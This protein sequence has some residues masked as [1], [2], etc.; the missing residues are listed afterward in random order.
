MSNVLVA[1]APQ[2]VL[3]LIY[4][5]YNGIFTCMLA[6]RE[7][8]QFAQ[9]RTGLRVSDGPRGSQ[10]SVYF[11]QLPYRFAVPIMILSGVLHW[12]VSQSI[13]LAAI[14]T[15]DG[16]R[17]V[18]YFSS[19]DLPGRIDRLTCGFSPLAIVFVIGLAALMLLFGVGMGRLR[20]VAGIPT[21]GS[22]S[23]VLSAACHVE[24]R[25]AGDG[26]EM[27]CKRLQWGVT[28]PGGGVGYDEIG[29]CGFSDTAVETPKEFT[30]YAGWKGMEHEK[31]E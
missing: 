21:A 18:L 3:S 14:E 28:R 17:Q 13:F 19:L 8:N 7:W 27:A 20:Y 29:H 11:L 24:K 30:Y 10:R 15:Y 4:F 6:E 25:T 2:P 22:R 12:L 16:G 31:M 23:I 26:D 5:I 9:K 1:N